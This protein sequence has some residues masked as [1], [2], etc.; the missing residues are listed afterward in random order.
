M[1]QGKYTVGLGQE[2]MA[3][4]GEREDIN[5][6]ALTGTRSPGAHLRGAQRLTI[7]AIRSRPVPYG[8]VRRAIRK[9][10]AP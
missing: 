3:F 8:E 1:S 4:C 6:V 10:R 2:R 5:S 9:S 7:V